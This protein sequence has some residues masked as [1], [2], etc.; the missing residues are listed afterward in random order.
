MCIL[1]LYMYL[2]TL[3]ILASAWMI[4]DILLSCRLNWSSHTILLLQQKSEPL[5]G[6]NWLFPFL[7]FVPSHTHARTHTHTHTYTHTHTHTGRHTLGKPSSLQPLF[8]NIQYCSDQGNSTWLCRPGTER[9][10]HT[11]SHGGVQLPLYCG[12]HGRGLQVHQTYQ[13]VHANDIV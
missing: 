11:S 10:V 1:K 8:F 6:F 5:D 13:E 12:W 7:V 4:F 9:S 2:V 3:H